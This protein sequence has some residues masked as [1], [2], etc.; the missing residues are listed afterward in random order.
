RRRHGLPPRPCPQRPGFSRIP[1]DI[2]PAAA[3]LYA[4]SSELLRDALEAEPSPLAAQPLRQQQE[5]DDNTHIA[6]LW[7][8]KLGPLRPAEGSAFAPSAHR[9]SSLH[10][11]RRG[12]TSVANASTSGAWAKQWISARHTSFTSAVRTIRL[13]PASSTS[14]KIGRA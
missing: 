7:P 4:R 13:M 3:T 8:R 12:L 1:A 6:Y 9:S 11:G 5:P 14:P 10:H 2:T